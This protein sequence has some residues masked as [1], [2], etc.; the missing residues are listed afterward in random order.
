MFYL[1]NDAISS[2]G[3]AVTDPTILANNKLELLLET[4][5]IS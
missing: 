3:Y 5:A 4:A 1:F 2:S